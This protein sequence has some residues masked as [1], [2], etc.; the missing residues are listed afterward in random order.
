[1]DSSD[2]VTYEEKNMTIKVERVFNGEK[3]AKELVLELL[4]KRRDAGEFRA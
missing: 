1:M 3:T 2:Q 4:K